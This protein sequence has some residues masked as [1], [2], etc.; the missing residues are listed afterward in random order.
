MRHGFIGFGNLGQA[1]YTGL[2]GNLQNSFIYYS[3]SKKKIKI[4]YSDSLEKL[5]IKSEHI[6]LCVKPKDVKEIFQNIRKIKNWEKIL[7]DKIFISVVA[8]LQT[9]KIQT[10]L[11]KNLEIV[12]LMPNIQIQDK[13]SITG[14]FSNSK[15]KKIKKLKKELVSLGLV[16]EITEKE[17]D[18]FTALFGSGPAFILEILNSIYTL[19]NKFK[20]EVKSEAFLKL[21][22]NTVNSLKD[23][24]NAKEIIGKITSKGG[25]TEAGLK[26]F[27][28]KKLDKIV[29]NVFFE[30]TKKSA[31]LSK[32][33][34]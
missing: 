7:A 14:F 25:T 24:E 1:I 26:Y 3:R 18:I 29:Q 34:T 23:L 5:F 17:F 15:S 10:E 31:K 19:K 12:R 8:G 13:Q 27:K 22:Q 16:I 11:S 20:T 9:K 2:K 21:F 6:W 32:L 4:E 30:A 33:F 28:K